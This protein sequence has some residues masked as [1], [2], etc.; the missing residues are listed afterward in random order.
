MTQSSMGICC[1]LFSLLTHPSDARKINWKLMI[2]IFSPNNLT[3]S[4]VQ[5]SDRETHL[6]LS[7]QAL[8][9]KAEITAAKLVK[10]KE[11]RAMKA[12]RDLVEA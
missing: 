3:I 6:H 7:S 8:A 5:L 4:L 10:L 1:Q 2:L 9:E 12:K 11:L